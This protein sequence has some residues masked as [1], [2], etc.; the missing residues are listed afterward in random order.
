LAAGVIYALFPETKKRTLEAIESIFKA[1]NPVKASLA[2]NDSSAS[3]QFDIETSVTAVE[4][5]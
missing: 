3:E 2:P 4:K 1:Q 5:K